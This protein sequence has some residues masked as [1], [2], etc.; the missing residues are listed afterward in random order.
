MLE[1][2]TRSALDVLEVRKQEEGSSVVVEGY[3]LLF[4]SWS[5]DLGGFKEVVNR[6]A[7]KNTNM[8]DVRA[9]FNH[10]ADHV[11][12]RTSAE[13]LKL[14]IDDKGLKFRFKTPDTSYGRDLAENLRNGNVNQCSFGFRIADEGDSFEYDSKEG[15]YKR[16]LNN[17]AEIADVSIVT[18]PA[19]SETS[20]APA[21][22]SIENIKKEEVDAQKQK[23]LE[24]R[25]RKLK[26]ELELS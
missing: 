21:L 16:S 20:V 8:S 15:I 24:Q 14:D 26:L 10:N 12:A 1:K 25:K 11:L 18:Y 9:L 5:E 19:Y 3:S 6:N 17:I 2:E 7:L 23:E 13:T 22:R 4:D